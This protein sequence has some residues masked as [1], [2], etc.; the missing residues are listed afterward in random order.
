MIGY[1]QYNQYE[2]F[3]LGNYEYQSIDG[4]DLNY[5][6]KALTLDYY[7]AIEDLNNYIITEW[8]ANSID[9]RVPDSNDA[10]TQVAT[11]VYT[12]KLALVKYFEGLLLQSSE[13]KSKGMTNQDVRSYEEDGVTIDDKLRHAHK[14][15]IM[16]MFGNVSSTVK[17]GD[18]SAFVYE[19]QKLLKAKGHDVTLDGVY[20]DLT[21]EAIIAFETAHNL[22]P[23]GKLDLFT[24]EQLLD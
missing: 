6:S 11:K 22:Y 12:K 16:G 13:L 14:T 4:I 7:E 17:M 15:K 21:I 8:S 24:L 9:V 3:A 1:G 20:K 10:E 5:H 23:D 2:R 18:K 19:I